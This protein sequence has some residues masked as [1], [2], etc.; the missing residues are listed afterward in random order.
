VT[1]ND[2]LGLSRKQMT[3][4]V[5]SQLFV[6]PEAMRLRKV[7][8][9]PRRTRVYS[10]LIPTRQGG[11][12]VE[13][14]GV[15]EY[16][17]GDSLRWI[18]WKA[19]ARH[20]KA[21]YINEFEQER[22]ADV[23][24]I[25]DARQRSDVASSQGSLFEHVIQATATLADALLNGGNRVGLLIYGGHLDWTYP[26]YGKIQRE[27]IF[28]ALARAEQGDSMVFEGLEYVPTSLFPARSQLILI[29]SLLAGDLEVLFRLRARGYSLLI[30]SP[31]SIAFEERSLRESQ[32]VE[33]ATRIARLERE[34]LLRKLRQAGI[35]ILDW[36]VET[37]FHQAAQVTLSRSPL[38]FRSLAGMR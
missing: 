14:F 3:L 7:E 13:F 36:N 5:P 22:V 29:S 25:V 20:S 2:S 31:D 12:G 19:S 32:D 35:T 33:L 15:R 23:G 8:I 9:R 6:L 11:P 4:G 30:V 28:R 34:L 21:L 16:Q 38:W 27:R 18:N 17:P 37:P 10:G 24:L 26:G 1:A